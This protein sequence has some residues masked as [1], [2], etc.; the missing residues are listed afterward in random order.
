MNGHLNEE[1]WAAAVLNEPEE[2]VANHLRECAPCCEEVKAFAAAIG[3]AQAAIREDAE[4]PESF[5][6]RQR[7][8]IA[9][10][11]SR[12]EFAPAWKRWI[13]VTATLTLVLLASMLVSRNSA[14][15]PPPVV[16]EESD[17]AL[18]L[19]VQ[20][21][22]RSDLPEALRPAV[23]LTREMDRAAAARRNP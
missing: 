3:G 7:E 1:R 6:R 2:S 4:R 8:S 20:Q 16:Q 22:I 10:R 21:S 15:P 17:D 19:H 12:G 14:P 18:L 5:W 23:L 11:R 13:W 9:A